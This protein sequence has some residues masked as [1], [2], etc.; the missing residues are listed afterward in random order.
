MKEKAFK[1]I[2]KSISVARLST[3]KNHSKSNTEAVGNYI[4]NAKISENF[5][6]LLQNLEVSLRNA[7]YNGFKKNY[8]NKDFFYLNE[9]NTRNRYLSRQEKHSRECWKMLC[10]AKY[11]LRNV[12]INDG[13]I[14]AEL[15]FGFWT[16]LLLSTDRKYMNMWRIIFS[17]VF[18]N[19]KILNSVDRDKMLIGRKIDKI[20]LFRNR[21]FHYEPIF[22]QLNLEDIH[23]AII[24]VIAWIDK[25][26]YHLSL[27][28]DDFK[29]INRDKQFIQKQ[30]RGKLAFKKGKRKL[31]R[32]R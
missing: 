20:R 12:R 9:T 6:F 4:L 24:E 2:E 19:Y 5:Y 22:N 15:N 16:K 18:P 11:N 27:M 1:N 8:Q 29:Y 25:D 32:K 17:D 21:I 26:M 23:D 13:K 30:L 3:Y 14:I 31:R 28:F 7:I 10:G